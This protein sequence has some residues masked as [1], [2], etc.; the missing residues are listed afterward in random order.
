V[1][2]IPYSDEV[3]NAPISVS[4]HEGQEMDFVISGK[5]KVK[6][7]GNTEVMQAGDCIYFD[8]GNPHGFAA[9]DGEDCTFLAVLI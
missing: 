5:M 7:G 9:L 3:L 4:A 1:V 6:I 8:A 2:T